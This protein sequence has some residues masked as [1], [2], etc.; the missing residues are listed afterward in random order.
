M[1]N[2][3]DLWVVYDKSQEATAASGGNSYP[4]DTEVS[5]TVT[6]RDKFDNTSAE[7]FQFKTETEYEHDNAVD[8][9]NL[10]ETTTQVGADYSIV[11]VQSGN[12]EGVQLIYANEEPIK[13]GF[14]PKLTKRPTSLSVALR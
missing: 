1:I 7:I 6:A 2:N 4:F 5:L 3:A 12:L 10:P 13:P 9:A 8:S 11:E 14:G